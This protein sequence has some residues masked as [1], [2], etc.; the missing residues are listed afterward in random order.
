VLLF[1]GAHPDDE[2][3]GPGGTLARYGAAGVTV[4]YACATRGEVGAADPEHLRGFASVG[5][6]RW[7]ELTCAA[8]EL[9]LAQVVHLGYRDSGM[10]GSP[11]N[12]HPDALVMA[13]PQEVAGRVVAVIRHVRPQVVVTFD[14]IGGYGHPDHIAIH[15]A[16]ARAFAAAGNRGEFPGHGPA[17]APSKLYYQV[18]PR[19]LLRLAIGVLPL[20]GRDPRRY[21]RN[22]D[23]D[24]VSL[25]G[26][27]FP[28]HARIR[29]DREARAR[30]GRAAACHRSQL[31]GGPP[32]RGLAALVARVVRGAECYM[33]A[34]PAADRQL[35]ETDLFEG[36]G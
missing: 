14:P 28:V 5:D 8:R 23:I 31:S 19:R 18:V 34:H 1:V 30:R 25:A 36:L 7:A 12:R 13:P 11:E 22:R 9:G 33:R 21:G 32:R 27:R 20:L 35:R 10:S 26:V 3:F 2:T 15:Q 24:L 29:L 16:T 17:F 4:V 6:M